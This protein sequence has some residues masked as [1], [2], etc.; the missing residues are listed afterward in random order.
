VKERERERERE[1]GKMW[2]LRE[3]ANTVI[4]MRLVTI[5][6]TITITG[7][8]EADRGVRDGQWHV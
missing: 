6:I 5:N 3:G 2:T 8:S 7:G 1:R 4:M